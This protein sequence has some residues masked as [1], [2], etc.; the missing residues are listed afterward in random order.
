VSFDLLAQHTA[1]VFALTGCPRG[2]VPQLAREGRL[3]EARRALGLLTDAFG[4]RVAMEVWDHGLP[5]ERRLVRRL[6]PLAHALGVPWVVTNNV[7]YAQ[8]GG[9]IVH[10]VLSAL[11]HERT[12]DS[13]GTRLR[14][15]AEWYLKSA[16]QLAV[17][18]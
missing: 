6:L 9:R 17:T 4:D 7:H 3:R 10:D 2:W 5:E 16:E 18:W 8:S 13:M 12:L 14:P 11:R 15:N 1:G